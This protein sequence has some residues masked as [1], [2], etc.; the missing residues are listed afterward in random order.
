MAF[1][2]S[3][4]VVSQ[5]AISIQV[6]LRLAQIKIWIMEEKSFLEIIVCYNAMFGTDYFSD[7]LSGNTAILQLKGES[8]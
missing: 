5:E 2:A 1:L 7:I 4:T 3:N 8:K 6:N